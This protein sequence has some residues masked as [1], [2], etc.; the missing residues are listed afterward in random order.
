MMSALISISLI[1]R[2]S[3]SHPNHFFLTLT[4]TCSQLCIRSL[5]LCFLVC[6][7]SLCRKLTLIRI[8]NFGGICVPTLD[9]LRVSVFSAQCSLYARTLSVPEVVRAFE[10]E[11]SL[12]LSI[13]Y[14]VSN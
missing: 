3:H 1:G 10:Y 14:L 13:S 9:A 8:V 5:N 12:S 2:C 6:N 7:A 4:I 11:S